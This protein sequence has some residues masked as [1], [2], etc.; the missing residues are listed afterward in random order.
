MESFDFLERIFQNLSFEKERK[1]FYIRETWYSYGELASVVAGIQDILSELEADEGHVG[2]Y[3]Q[4]DIYT[5]ASILALW[6]TGLAFVPL[7][8]LFPAARN[9]KILEQTTPGALLHSTSLPGEL[10]I[11]GCRILRTDRVSI[12]SGNAPVL[13]DF[14]KEKDAYVMFTSGSTGEPKGVRISFANLNAFIRDF[15]SYPVYSFSREDRFLQIYDLTFDASIPC[16]TVALSVGASVYT[17]APGGIKYL[18]AYK[19][20]KEQELTFVKMPPSTLFYLR[21]HFSGIHLPAVKYCLFGGEAFPAQL[22]DEFE[23]CIPNAL[24]QNVYGPTELTVNCHIYDWN[25][26]GSRRKK[27]RGIVSIGRAFGTNRMM[28]EAKE[29]SS[30]AAE[31][32]GEL[33][34][35]G[36]LMVTGEQVSPGYWRDSEPDGNS[37]YLLEKDGSKHRYYRTGDQVGMDEEGDLFF[38]GRGDEQVQVRGYRVELGEIESL[39]RSWMKGINV[40]AAALEKQTGEMQIVLLLE[41]EDRDTLP[42]REYLSDQLPS[43]ML[44]ED[45]I[46]MKHFP[47]QVSGKTDR[48]AII[49]QLLK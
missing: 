2:L 4:D 35:S 49:D 8:P 16:Y 24:I 6:M 3:L 40:M 34:V 10:H 17:V 5:Y 7:T 37:F 38:L 44:P 27:H 23:A 46:T 15:I 21:K 30:R 9:R 14:G 31:Q 22:A 18:E 47:R 28:I 48:K 29:Q 1:A 41:S 12:V 11:S 39:A 13:Y 36:E 19:L 42:L 45:I 25:S 33:P 20:M 32:K 43:Y 26:P